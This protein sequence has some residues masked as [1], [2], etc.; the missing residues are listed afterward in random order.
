MNITRWLTITGMLAVAW[1]G[2]FYSGRV[3]AGS[4][5]TGVGTPTVT[6]SRTD[7][8]VPYWDLNGEYQV[9]HARIVIN[10]SG[11]LRGGG[12]VQEKEGATE[13]SRYALRFD[14]VPFPMSDL[15]VADKKGTRLSGM[16][17]VSV[18]M[19]TDPEIAKPRS[20]RVYD[21]IEAR[22]VPVAPEDAAIVRFGISAPTPSL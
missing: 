18:E 13:V 10:G 15:Q 16:I 11:F 12:V 3:N 17:R 2:F 14:D 19:L 21:R 5:I 22:F 4:V 9:R 20:F 7:D 8:P 6:F 1:G